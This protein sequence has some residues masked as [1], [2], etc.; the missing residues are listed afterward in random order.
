MEENDV[1]QYCD[2]PG[3]RIK[4]G[5]INLI[6]NNGK[7]I[8]LVC[9]SLAYDHIMDFPGKFSEHILAGKTHILNLSFTVNAVKESFGGTGGNIAYNLAL[10]GGRPKIIA[11]AGKDFS[12]YKKWLKKNKI[13]AEYVKVVKTEL[14]ASA[15]IMT[16]KADNQITAYYPGAKDIIKLNYL[17]IIGSGLAENFKKLVSD[18]IT[19]ALDSPRILRGGNDKREGGNDKRTIAIIAPDIVVRMAGY[20]K[21]FRQNKIPYIFDP[22]QQVAYY[23]ADEL[24]YSILGAKMLIGNDYEIQLILN[25]LKIKLGALEKMAEILVITKGGQGAEIYNKNKKIVVPAAKKK[26][27]V[28]PTG[29][30]DAYRAGF[31]KGLIMDWP[32][33][34]CARLASVVAAYAVENQGTQNHRFNWPEVNKRYK[35]NYN[36][37]L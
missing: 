37:S 5:M 10:L 13:D 19:I 15:Y 31:I 32:L 11:V 7:N 30:G 3:S 28:D 36:E 24:K 27:V 35:D 34:K 8:I 14:T 18:K 23:S 12:R 16:D 20:A 29:A 33:K 6:M 9:G 4:S 17:K 2:S 25:K 26:A 22:G 1:G 21:I